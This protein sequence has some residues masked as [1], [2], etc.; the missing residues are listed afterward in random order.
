MPLIIK[1]TLLYLLLALI[2]FSVGGVITYRA[3][4]KVVQ[5]ETDYSLRRDLRFLARSIEQG[6]SATAFQNSWVE[7]RKLEGEGIAE[8]DPVI[9][10][11][12]IFLRRLN[13]LEP[14]RKLEAV[15]EIN[16]DYYAFKISEVYIESEDV[17][18]GVLRIMTRLF[19][20]LTLV[21][22]L[23]SLIIS[24][25]LFSPFQETLKQI[26]Q[27]NLKQSSGVQ[28]PTTTTREFR[29]LNDFI[30]LM[31]EKARRDYINLKEFSENASHEM[32]TPLAVAQGK[33]EILQEREDLSEEHLLLLQEAQDS[34]SRLSK[35]Q[36][37]LSL[38]TKIEN[39]E[40]P[41]SDPVDLSAALERILPGFRELSALRGVT[42][43]EQI[44]PG[45]SARLDAN[46][47]EILLNN[48]LRNALQHNTDDGWIDVEL[49]AGEL[50]IRNTG[51]APGVA[52]EQLFDRF[53]KGSSR[54]GSLGLGLSIVRKICD[55]AGFEV[56]YHYS[57]GIHELSVRF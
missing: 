32:Q 46:L 29:E 20:Y 57:Q 51:P 38:L 31:T 35:L 7:I 13:R 44:E 4:K 15:R 1:T 55:S 21:L 52:P 39:R 53:R 27:F 6:N 3:V 56:S 50:L 19:L 8:S 42:I 25:R 36:R 54:S 11:T 2:V 24:R 14:H 10:D 22:S 23:F 30:R 17:Y 45:V 41:N 12:L 47:M 5:Q 18:N 43:K 34:L 40:F 49:N 26:Q 28:L 16:G 37:G 48:L 9:T 33:L